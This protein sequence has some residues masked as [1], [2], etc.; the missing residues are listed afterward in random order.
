[1]LVLIFG[2]EN[3]GSDSLPLR[4]LSRLRQQFPD[5][6]F[7]VKDPHEELELS[8]EPFIIIDTAQGIKST[9]LFYDLAS[10]VSPPR[11]TSHDFD[12]LIHLRYLEKIGRMPKIKI[13][14]IPPTITEDEALKEVRDLLSRANQL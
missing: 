7:A 3:L 14:G 4:I 6:N 13:I 11:I 5:L 1:M 9:A 10:F 2:N 8:G 12:A